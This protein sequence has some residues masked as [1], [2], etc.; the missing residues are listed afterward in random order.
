MSAHSPAKSR[1][2]QQL[3]SLSHRLLLQVAAPKCT[4]E[5]P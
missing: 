3:W 5:I 4:V 2:Q 1:E